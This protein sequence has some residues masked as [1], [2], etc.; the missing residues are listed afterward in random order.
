MTDRRHEAVHVDLQSDGFIQNPYPAYET[1]RLSEPVFFDRTANQWFLSR[2]KD[3][4]YALRHVELFSNTPASFEQTLL[5]APPRV[6]R[7]TRPIAARALSADWARSLESFIAASVQ[8][9][10]DAAAKK[11]QIDLVKALA[12]PLP[13]RVFVEFVGVR[14]LDFDE[15]RSWVN[16]M[17]GSPVTAPGENTFCHDAF[18]RCRTFIADFVEREIR[19][20]GTRWITKLA[21]SPIKDENLSQAECVDVI[22]LLMIAATVTTTS[23]IS[24]TL[25][26]LLKSA[27]TFEM[28]RTNPH[29]IAT[30]LE[31]ALR[32]ES[33]VQRTTRTTTS[34]ALVAGIEI[35]KDARV[36]LLIGSANRDE[37]VFDNPNALDILRSPNPHIA[38][39]FGPHYC[40][41]AKLSRMEAD[42]AVRM[43]LDRFPKCRIIDPA[44]EYKPNYFV[45]SLKSLMVSL[46]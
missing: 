12:E 42:I 5:G 7:R 3:V 9:L 32:Y 4:C 23:L 14:N 46:A 25:A 34:T 41:G 18:E 1:L 29:R 16:M 11:N 10:L 21:A 17:L 37:V 22:M 15:A 30:L 6:H 13:M 38:F 40:L 36:E 44:L 35:P 24:S 33:P 31:E 26:F 2:Y 19:A 39:G 45:R 20:N 8:E 27:N 43:F 28:I